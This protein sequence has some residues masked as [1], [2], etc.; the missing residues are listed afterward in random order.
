LLFSITPQLEH[1]PGVSAAA[2]REGGKWEGEG[3]EIN[4][5][6]QTY[7]TQLEFRNEKDAVTCLFCLSV[8]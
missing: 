5:K 2:G 3:K 8:L 1:S 6:P 7:V 4:K